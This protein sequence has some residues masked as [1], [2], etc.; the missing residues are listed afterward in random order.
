MSLPVIHLLGMKVTPG[1][2]PEIHQEISRLIHRKKPGIILS[3]NVYS[4]NLC[5]QLPWLA[6]F[7]EQADIVYPDG[8]GIS[9]GARLLNL[10]RF[11]R[12]TMAEWIWPASTYLAEQGHS[13]YLLGNPPGVAARA[14]AKLQVHEPRLRILGRHHGFFAKAGPENEAV[15][16]AINRLAPDV[17][18]VGL[19]MPLEQRWILDNYRRLKARVFWEVGAAFEVWAGVIPTCPPW[20]GELGLNWLFRL[21]L[22]PRRLARRYLIGNP[23]FLLRVLKEKVAPREEKWEPQA[24]ASTP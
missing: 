18:M 1:K 10:G 7:Y 15:I 8:A 16:E 21:L 20:L 9:W 23:A 6:K 2:L 5:R 12:I 22:E 3:G 17:L 11:Q 14:A 19:G 24:P 4:L 13:L